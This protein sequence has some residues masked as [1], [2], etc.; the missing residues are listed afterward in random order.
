MTSSLKL[1]LS[2][3]LKKV[4]DAIGKHERNEVAPLSIQLLVKIK[5]ELEEMLRVMNPNVYM[6]GYS[7]YILDWPDDDGLIEEL[8]NVSYQYGKIRK[9]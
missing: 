9:K 8:I 2:C 7:R 5:K 4:V 1:L 6:P 3:V